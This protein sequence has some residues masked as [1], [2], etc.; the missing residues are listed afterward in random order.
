MNVYKMLLLSQ[1]QAYLSGIFHF[2]GTRRW[3]ICQKTLG[4]WH[5]LI[6]LE[7]VKVVPFSIFHLNMPI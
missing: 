2:V 6:L 1:L 5:L 7:A 4:E 3:G